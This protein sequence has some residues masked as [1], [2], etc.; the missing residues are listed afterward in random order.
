MHASG[1]QLGTEVTNVPSA[2]PDLP[3]PGFHMILERG[4]IQIRESQTSGYI[5]IPPGMLTQSP[6]FLPC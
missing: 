1:G 6:N 4:K 3:L 2:Q 5:R